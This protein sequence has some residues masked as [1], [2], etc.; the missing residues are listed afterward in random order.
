MAFSRGS[1]RVALSDAADTSGAVASIPNPEGRTV[2]VTALIVNLTTASSGAGTVDAGISANSTTL[3][4][5]LIDGLNVNAATGVFSNLRE[6]G[7]NGKA[8][9]PWGA[10]QYLTISRASGAVAGLRGEAIVEY[11]VV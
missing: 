8:G 7:S 9:Q 2:Y 5:T 3:S 1:F 6:P 4:D 10:T 11:L